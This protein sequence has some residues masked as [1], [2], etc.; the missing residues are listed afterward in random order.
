MTFHFFVLRSLLDFVFLDH[1]EHKGYAIIPNVVSAETVAALNIAIDGACETESALRREGT[2]YGM[3][4]ALKALPDVSR[5]ARSEN[6]I[7]LIRPILGLRAF[8]VR[9]LIFDKTPEA[10]WGVPWHQD[11]TIAVKQ[12]VET[13]GFGPWTLKLG[14]HHVRPPIEVLENM[15]TLRIHL[16]DCH[17]DQGPLEV[18]AGSHKEGRIDPDGTRRWLEQEEPSACL[19]DR[20]GVVMI[21]PLLLHSSSA[22]KTPRR[23]RVV[24]LE[25]AANPLP[26][27]LQWYESI[28]EKPQ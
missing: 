8:A 24:H 20:G 25:Y 16:D 1:F 26:G 18:I 9:G 6:L 21:R 19:T 15:V 7:D 28:N 27:S 5:L 23:R 13:P 22:A 11:L 17:D 3:R 2:L 12:R 14:I 4:D 10:N